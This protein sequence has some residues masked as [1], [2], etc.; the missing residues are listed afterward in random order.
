MARK[1]ANTYET[2]NLNFHENYFARLPP[3]AS[4]ARCGPHPRTLLATPLMTTFYGYKHS[5]RYT[6]H[7]LFHKLEIT[8]SLIIFLLILRLT[9]TSVDTRVWTYCGQVDAAAA[10]ASAICATCDGS[11]NLVLL[12]PSVAR[13]LI[14]RLYRVAQNSESLPNYK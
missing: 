11:N 10:G 5:N 13:N 4:A 9:P 3:I 2:Y 14:S 1:V 7:T 6:F 12:A 8:F